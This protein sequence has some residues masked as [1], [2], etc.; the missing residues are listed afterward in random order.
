M[1]VAQSTRRIHELQRLRNIPLFEEVDEIFKA[2]KK[3]TWFYNSRIKEFQSF[4]LKLETG[5]FND[6]NHLE[7]FFGC[8]LV[9]E[10]S[11][12]IELATALV[13]TY[14]KI[15]YKRPEID[16]FT[17]K[18]AY[19]FLFDDLRL[20]VKLK[21]NLSL[22]P[23]EY[24]NLVFEIQIKTFLQHAWAIATHDLIYK[25]DTVDWAKERIAYQI[26]AMLEHAE[27]SILEVDNLAK[28][29]GLAKK[30]KETESIIKISDFVKSTWDQDDLPLDI[31]RLAKNIR[32]I[33]EKLEL[34]L[35]ILINVVIEETSLGRGSKTRNLSPI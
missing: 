8:L 16:N 27:V 28:T 3:D 10:N 22:P 12:S 9:V 24:R 32:T 29:P 13:D 30:N 5:R 15:E 17:S 6:S 20:Y 11:T 7:D 23:K 2:N 14:F 33:C 4:A 25:S 34:S 31:V 18:E 19:S 35:E 21:N 1:K 26:K